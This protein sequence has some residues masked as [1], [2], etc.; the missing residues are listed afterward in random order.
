MPVLAGTSKRLRRAA[1]AGA[2]VLGSAVAIGAALLN[3][4]PAAAQQ[5]EVWKSR[6]CG[7]CGAWIDH[8]REAGFPVT[9]HDTEDMAP[10]KARHGVPAP[11][12]SCHTATVDGYVIEGH[13]PAD[14]IRRLLTERPKARGL[15]APG[16]PASAPGMDMGH[17]PYEVVLFGGSGGGAKVFARH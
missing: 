11:L 13:V 2:V 6:S 5:V 8:L 14:D 16:M 1:L 15:S 3:G 7:C 12:Q 4:A 17:E 9:A 10:I